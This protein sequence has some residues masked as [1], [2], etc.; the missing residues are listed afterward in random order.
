MAILPMIAICLITLLLVAFVP[1][2]TLSL[3]ALF[4]G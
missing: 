4:G 3:P 2:F 1:A